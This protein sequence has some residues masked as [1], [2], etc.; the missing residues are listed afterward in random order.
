MSTTLRRSLTVALF[1][2]FLTGCKSV[3]PIGDTRPH[4]RLI[5]VTSNG[6]H[7]AIVVTAP[8]LVATGAIPEL[9]RGNRTYYPD[10]EKTF[11]M[12]LSAALVSTPA[13]CT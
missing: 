10:N 9:G 13:L 3:S 11:G 2:L 8:A 4:T 6:W 1:V 7:A 5:H 12:T